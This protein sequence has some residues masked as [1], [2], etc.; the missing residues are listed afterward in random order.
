M[1]EYHGGKRE[2]KCSSF[3]TLAEIHC[4]IIFV[5]FWSKGDTAAKVKKN[6]TTW[7]FLNS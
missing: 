7:G 1:M 6:A 5:F 2:R 3:T 4:S